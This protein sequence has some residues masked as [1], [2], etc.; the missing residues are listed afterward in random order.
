M[1][2]E[3]KYFYEFGSF[4]LD[5]DERVL[6]RDGKPVPLTPKVFHL[7]KILV[8][9]HGHIVDKEKLIAEIWADSFVEEGN[10][11]VSAMM[12]RKALADNASDPIFIE[13]IPRRGY[14]FIADVRCVEANDKQ[15]ASKNDGPTPQ[16]NGQQAASEEF[17]QA[18]NRNESKRPD[19]VVALAD[20]RSDLNDPRGEAQEV[21]S[22][23]SNRPGPRI[24][25]VPPTPADEKRGNRDS[26][27]LAGLVSIIALAG[28]GY[29]LYRFANAR[30]EPAA[31]SMSKAKRLSSNGKTKFAAI[32]PD[33]K[34]AAYIVDGGDHQNIRLKNIATGSDVEILPPEP[35]TLGSLTFSPD[36]NYLYYGAKG[37]LYQLPVL[38]GT[39]RKILEPYSGLQPNTISFSPDGKQFAFVRSP[40]GQK[41]E[42]PA[43][44]I[45][46]T[47]GGNERMLASGMHLGTALGSAAWSPDG[48]TIAY[49]ARKSDGKFD[50]NFL[51]VADGAILPIAGTR[52]R[53]VVQVIWQPP[54]DELLVIASDQHHTFEIWALSFS[55][56]KARKLTEDPYG[57]QSISLTPD[58]RSMVAARAEQESHIWMM[59]TEDTSQARQLTDGFKKYDGIFSIGWQRSGSLIY[60]AIPDER[61]EFWSFDT[62]G[63]TSKKIT[64]NVSHTAASPDGNYLVFTNPNAGEEDGL[65]RLSLVDGERMRL[66]TGK[67]LWATFSPDSKWV[68][69]NRFGED[70]GVWKVSIEGGEAIKLTNSNLGLPVSPAVSPDGKLI[71]FYLGKGAGMSHPQLSI[72]PNQGGGIVKAFNMPNGTYETFA[73][74]APVQW[75]PDGQ[76][77]SY[78]VHRDGV[79]NIW[80]QSIGGREPVQVTHFS[81]GL[82]F[83]FAYSPNEKHLALSRGTVSR[84]VVLINKSE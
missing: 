1:S 49:A 39:P 78:V 44:F 21:G 7:L 59:P 2:L 10:L 18:F 72:I 19:A 71:A 81:S 24:E 38:G 82:I 52:W 56:G 68:I 16:L 67:D 9:N 35:T 41:D 15:I 31:F 25:L 28:V 3:T 37:K 79:S 6:V 26:Y 14:R 27:L 46:D 63:G 13:T 83:N 69:F 22:A 65:F 43:V 70:V 8:Q 48:R 54:G 80:R 66:T 40:S 57:Y 32:S 55:T 23:K 5:L 62:S 20:W 4:R 58:G 77:V 75:T 17:P 47:D 33:G 74:K 30:P 50:V 76:A 45:A 53:R 12:L 29:A 73:G 61:G 51:R 11:A 34:F 42:V 64:D 60:E 84:D 36:A